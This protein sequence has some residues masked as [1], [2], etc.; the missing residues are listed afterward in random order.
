MT[1]PADGSLYAG[2]VT[3]RRLKPRRHALAYRVFQVLIDLDRLDD[4]DARLRLFSRN[5]FNVLSFHDRDHG[6]GS[7]TPLRARLTLIG[8]LAYFVSPFDL[9]PDVLVGLGF[10][11]DTAILLAAI[12]AVRASIHDRHRA[13]RR[14]FRR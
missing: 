13:A 11:D 9:V 4:L 3:H 14:P 1:T 8:A 5:G 2:R 10:V 6:D 12:S 7:A